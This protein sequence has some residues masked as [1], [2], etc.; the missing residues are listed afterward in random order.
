MVGPAGA[1]KTLLLDTLAKVKG[2]SVH[3]V[4]LAAL[5]HD[6]MY[7]SYSLTERT[8]SHGVFATLLKSLPDSGALHW[9]VLDGHATALSFEPLNPVMDLQRVLSLASNERIKLADHTRVALE[10]DTVEHLSPANISRCQRLLMLSSDDVGSAAVLSAALRRPE[11]AT[12]GEA[13]RT[14][15]AERFEALV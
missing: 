9:I 13:C 14:G 1:G 4:Q 6:Q 7:C 5:S 10:T 3:R 11:L 12:L 15:L 2:H 8:W